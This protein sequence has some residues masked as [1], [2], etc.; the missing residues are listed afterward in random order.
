MIFDT[1]S[2]Y[3]LE[4][5]FDTW[6]EHWTKAQEKGVTTSI[7]VGT[8]VD[9][10]RRAIELA[11]QNS[12]FKATV[13]I[14]PSDYQYLIQDSHL[15]ASEIENLI[16]GHLNEL[17][18]LVSD[19]TV[20]AVGETGLDYFRLPSDPNIGEVIKNAQQTAF[21]KHIE[22]AVASKLPLI[23]HVRDT[24]EA[25]YTDILQI[26][27]DQPQLP[28]FILH[29]VSGPLSYIEEALQLGA[30]LGIAGNSTYPS[31][32]HIRNIIRSAP[33]D[34]L[35]LETDAPFLPPQEFRGKTCEPWMI[36]LTA[37][38]VSDELNLDLAQLYQNAKT[39]FTF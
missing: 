21:K 25:A 37:E 22:L 9:T 36:A 31:A 38:F 1:H 30:Y 20:V 23:I 28:A 14:H 6:E 33:S 24:G 12:A 8:D 13:A 19:K 27:K 11:R 16:A 26:L 7:V 10:S 18:T 32:E 35:L 2:H 29:C 5:L 34:K 17:H 15:T 4:P 3:N 39:F